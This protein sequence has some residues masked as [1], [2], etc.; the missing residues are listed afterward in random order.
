MSSPGAS[1]RDRRSDR[2]RRTLL[3]VGAVVLVLAVVVAVVVLASGGSDNKKTATTGTTTPSGSTVTTR[4]G[5]TTATTRA[6]DATATTAGPP[7]GP[8]KAAD[9]DGA[10]AG[11]TVRGTNAVSVVSVTNTG[12]RTCTI[13]GYPGVALLGPNNAKV[14]TTVAQGGGG[15]P[16]GLT[17]QAI[18][19]DPGAKAS[20]VISWDQVSGTCAD[21]RS[22]DVTLP[23]DS[24]V[25]NV[26]SSVT[27]CGNG[28]VNVSPFQ[29][30]TVSA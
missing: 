27:V 9:V 12:K 8:C 15:V 17:A 7:G 1:R 2:R 4:A 13:N 6:S 11:S 18:S 21:V 22:F 24:K 26:Q 10:M 28:A 25:S 23:G 20:F 29:P 19:L 30:G 5:G 14:Q 3:I 16:A